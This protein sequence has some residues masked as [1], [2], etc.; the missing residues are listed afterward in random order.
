MLFRPASRGP[1]G[2]VAVIHG[3]AFYV[4]YLMATGRDIVLR[5]VK[6]EYTFSV[7]QRFEWCW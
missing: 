3:I 5:D 7:L 2:C 1:C 6:G 4:H